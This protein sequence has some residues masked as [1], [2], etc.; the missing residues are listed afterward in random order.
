MEDSQRKRTTNK[1]QNKKKYYL[2]VEIL[3][4]HENITEMYS[5]FDVK[6][7]FGFNLICQQLRIQCNQIGAQGD[8]VVSHA[9]TQFNANG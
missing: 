4:L 2:Q 6:L 3:N 8:R 7:L 9:L 1:L 5:G